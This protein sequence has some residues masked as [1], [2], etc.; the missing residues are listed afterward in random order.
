LGSPYS[1]ITVTYTNN[2]YVFT[3]PTKGGNSQVRIINAGGN[4]ATTTLKLMASLG[5]T[6]IDG[7]SES[8]PWTTY[9]GIVDPDTG[10][11]YTTTTDFADISQRFALFYL[12]Y[13]GGNLELLEVF[14]NE[15]FMGGQMYISNG[16]LYFSGYR[17]K[18]ITMS[19]IL[20]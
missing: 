20:G 17:R 14:P 13:P 10:V 15:L 4:D 19:K 12:P 1:G 11:Y 8:F 5:S 16:Y 3:S 7:T 18:L 6:V 2:L 9:N